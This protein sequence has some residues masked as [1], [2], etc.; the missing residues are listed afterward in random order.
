MHYYV[1]LYRKYL[2]KSALGIVQN[3]TKVTDL[4][5]YEKQHIC[6]TLYKYHN[7]ILNVVYIC[8]LLS[9]PVLYTSNTQLQ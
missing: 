1:T 2:T 4:V 5:C 3:V 7:H 6:F 9:M 8:D